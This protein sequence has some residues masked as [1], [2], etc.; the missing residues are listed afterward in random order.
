MKKFDAILVLGRGTRRNGALPSSMR[1]S[2]DKAVELYNSGISD[3][4]IFCGKWSYQIDYIPKKTEAHLMADYAK[5]LGLPEKAIFIEDESVVTTLNICYAKQKYLVHNNWKKILVI[6]IFPL[7][8]RMAYNLK[9]ILGKE[10]TFE[11]EEIEYR[12]SPEKEAELIISEKNK[13]KDVVPIF[14]KNIIPGDDK[15]IALK[16]IREIKKINRSIFI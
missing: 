1:A 6:S 13:L 5:S 10:Y 4:I 2:V 15:K 7:Q 16:A 14:F 3:H 9:M 12:F 11:F 8:D